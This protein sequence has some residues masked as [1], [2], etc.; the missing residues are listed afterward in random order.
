MYLDALD[1]L[2]SPCCHAEL[3]P[4]LAAPDQTE[5]VSGSLTCTACGATYAVAKGMPLL[6][7]DDER[8]VSKAKEAE[9][10]VTYHKE[11]GIYELT[12]DPV[13]LRIPYYPEE[14]WIGVARSFDLA[15]D[16]L[17]LTGDETVLDL[18]AGRGW[19]AKAFALKG[20]R[21]MAVDVVTDELIGLGR[22]RA[23]MD[24]AGTYFER[25]I[26][27]GE[28]LPLAP[29]S[30][31]IIFASAALHHFSDLDAAFRQVATLLKPG[32]VLCAIREPAIPLT[33][34]EADV[35]TRD[36]EPETAVGINE[37]RPSLVEYQRAMARAGL[38]LVR[39]A[40]PDMLALE[41]A[42][43]EGHMRH[44]GAIRPRG[45]ALWEP[46]TRQAYRR[47]AGLRGRALL[48]GRPLADL[49]RFSDTTGRRQAEL[50]GLLW[51]GGE[52]ILIARKPETSVN[53]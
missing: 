50:Q 51:I 26:G 33:E 2:R 25:V 27:D 47:Y 41:D 53:P 13:D 10:W 28:N 24:D 20:C 36:A 43:L 37:T 12:D 45:Y 29:G 7:V 15:L 19:A 31:D 32:G 1:L 48:Q 46:Q 11:L 39:A 8:W 4:T 14:P 18:G 5:I 30:F 3:T 34:R 38:A 23:L 21:V 6:Y 17:N 16:L 42:D 52:L 40:T 49:R 22:G 35:L 9:G 44:V